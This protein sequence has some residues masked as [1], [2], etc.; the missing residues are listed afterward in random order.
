MVQR[1]EHLNSSAIRSASWDS[2]TGE[3]ELVFTSDQSYSFG[4]VP[5]HIFEGLVTARSAGSYYAQQIKG[6]Y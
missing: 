1:L 6:R 4:N 5:E 2:E 3:M